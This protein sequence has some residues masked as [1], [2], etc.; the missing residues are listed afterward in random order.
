MKAAMHAYRENQLRNIYMNWYLWYKNNV[1]V[2]DVY[3][4]HLTMSL[5][6]LKN[7]IALPVLWLRLYSFITQAINKPSCVQHIVS[8]LKMDTAK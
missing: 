3:M 4:Q 2:Y 5:S 6:S 8:S 1:R 7:N